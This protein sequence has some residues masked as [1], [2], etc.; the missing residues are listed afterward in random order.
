MEEIDLLGVVVTISVVIGG[1]RG[2]R[3]WQVITP[4]DDW[5]DHDWY[6]QVR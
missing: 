3:A 2:V 5:R 1:T 6:H 4:D